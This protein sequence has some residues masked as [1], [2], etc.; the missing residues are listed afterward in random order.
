V[1]CFER[2]NRTSDSVK[3]RDFLEQGTDYQLL[4]G[5]AP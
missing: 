2:G 1:G 5:S 4:E 3:D